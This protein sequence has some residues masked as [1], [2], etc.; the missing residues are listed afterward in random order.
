MNKLKNKIIAGIFVLLTATSCFND[1]DVVPLDQ[2]VVTSASVYDDPGAYKQ[3]LA[4]LYAVLALSGQSGP[5]GQPDI[6]G[7][8]EGFSNYIRQYWK[9]QQLTT[10]ETIIAWKDGTIHD[11]HN[12]VWT[13]SNEF[14]TAM[15]N[16]IFYMVSLSNE[17][18]RESTTEK[19]NERSVPDDIKADVQVYRAEA[20]L[21]RAMAYYHAL[22]MFGNVPFVTEAD[23]VGAFLPQQIERADLFSFVES[24]LLAIESELLDAGQ[25]VYGRVDKGAA[26]MLL[27]KLYLNAEVYIGADKYDEAIVY[28]SK[29]ANAA[30]AL[31]TEYSNLFTA[32][33]G[34]ASGIIFAVPFDGDRTRTWGGMTFL[35]HASVGGTM[36]PKGFG[37]DGGWWGL[38]TTE[39][40]VD[41]WA[42]ISG[43]TDARAMMHTDGQTLEID[44]PFEFTQGYAITKY[45]NMN[46][47][48]SAGQREDFP[49]TDFV[50]FRLADAYLMY[51]E[52]VLRGGSGG[53]VTTALGYVNAL[54]NRAY[55]DNSGNIAAGDLTLDFVLDERSRELYWEGHRRTDLIRFG[56][57]SESDYV[58][59]W[60]G[61]VRD[62]VSTNSKFDLFPIPSS[63]MGANTN[64]KQNTGY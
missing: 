6:S 32:D 29:V 58:W 39:A 12:Q 38:R 18:L 4:K 5:D 62:G 3:V 2:N 33:N 16:R 42:D 27:S 51:A 19:L 7:I 35:I 26:W 52:A 64:L 56:K 49:D 45:T 48:G 37:I 28:S 47:N 8:D 61:G 20:R 63:D 55:G 9:A 24:E 34:N 54:R 31:E 43:N 23:G 30:Y 10:D 36:D 44:D 46:S 15:Y 53:D 21:L 57:F 14:I 11:L 13:P 22:D 60:K 41:K 59:P 1:L 50:M 40:F 25:N 17:F